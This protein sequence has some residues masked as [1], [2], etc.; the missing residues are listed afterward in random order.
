M[1]ARDR[2]GTRG[3]EGRQCFWCFVSRRGRPRASG[4]RAEQE[5]GAAGAR[6]I[7]I[8]R[9]ALAQRGRHAKEAETSCSWTRWRDTGRLQVWLGSV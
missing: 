2:G 1:L 7:F 5:Q 9:N 6:Q 3:G 8:G 4:A